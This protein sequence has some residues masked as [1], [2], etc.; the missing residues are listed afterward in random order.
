MYMHYREMPGRSGDSVSRMRDAM[1]L[2]VHSV[3]VSGG[4][5][6]VIMSFLE[7]LEPY[8]SVAARKRFFACVRNNPSQDCASIAVEEKLVPSFEDY[9][10][11][12][13]LILAQGKKSTCR[14]ATE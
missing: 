14:F 9:G 11:E 12:I 5:D 6:E 2:A 4:E 13:D 7:G 10:D 3:G 8:G 1:I